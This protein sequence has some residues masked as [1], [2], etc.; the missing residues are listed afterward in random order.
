MK[1]VV[2]KTATAPE[3]FKRGKALAQLADAGQSLPEEHTASFGE[4]TDL[5]TLP[6]AA[7]LQVF[8]AVK[9]HPPSPD[10][11]RGSRSGCTVITAPSST[12]SINSCAQ[13]W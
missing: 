2:L 13:A 8:R 3:F 9:D 6:T 4:P 5:L 10:H 7:R 1:S 11:G 12:M